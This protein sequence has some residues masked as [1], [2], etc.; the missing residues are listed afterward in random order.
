MDIKK[1]LILGATSDT[2]RYAY[3]AANRLADLGHTIVNAGVQTGI[4]AGVPIELPE[5]IYDDIHTITLYI[6]PRKQ[7]ILYNYILDTNPR[8]IIFNPGTENHK[9]Q[10]L[11]TERGIM[12]ECACTLV[13]LATDQY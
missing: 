7:A 8:R 12:T 11:A 5:M 2:S 10:Q 6:S 13:L 9:L 3:L 4:V 1:T